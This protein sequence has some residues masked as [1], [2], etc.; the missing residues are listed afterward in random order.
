MTPIVRLDPP[1]CCEEYVSGPIRPWIPQ[2]WAEE[3]DRTITFGSDAHTTDWLAGNF[4][5][6][7][8]MAEHFGFQPDRR[9]EDFWSR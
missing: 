9:P 5:K 2:W 7:M 4:Y 3:G 6:A 1:P 8:A